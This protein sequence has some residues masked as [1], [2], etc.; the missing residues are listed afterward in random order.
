MTVAALCSAFLLCVILFRWNRKRRRRA[1]VEAAEQIRQDR[2]E[3]RRERALRK[4]AEPP[5]AASLFGKFAVES[6]EFIREVRRLRA[7]HGPEVEGLTAGAMLFMDAVGIIRRVAL[8]RDEIRLSDGGALRDI[9]RGAKLAS[10]MHCTKSDLVR[11]VENTPDQ[12]I[13]SLELLV[14]RGVS[15][16][17]KLR[18]R[19]LAFI[20]ELGG[21]SERETAIRMEINAVRLFGLSGEDKTQEARKQLEE[22]AGK[23]QA[24]TGEFEPTGYDL[25]GVRENC[26]D[27]E[28]KRAYYAKVALWHP[29]KLQDVAPELQAMANAK[30]AKLNSTY[31]SLCEQRALP[32]Q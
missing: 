29:D 13:T 2:R 9:I 6:K 28:L 1:L 3:Q 20:E 25:L 30:L 7:I 23:I 21:P 10:Y 24:L 11:F 15:D 17:S 32:N 18:T 14:E 5:T 12:G 8:D 4:K 26:S 16:V 22:L 31:Q 27:R 19:L